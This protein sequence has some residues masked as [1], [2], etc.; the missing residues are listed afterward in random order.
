MHPLVMPSI[1]A[2]GQ[3]ACPSAPYLHPA[4]RTSAS[5]QLVVRH[6]SNSIQPTAYIRYVDSPA[7][8]SLLLTLWSDSATIAFSA[9]PES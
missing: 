2:S 4:A 8:E 9:T 5:W 1:C 7:P 3:C 6:L